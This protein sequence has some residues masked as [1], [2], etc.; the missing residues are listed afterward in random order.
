MK[1]CMNPPYGDMISFQVKQCCRFMKRG[2]W[3]KIIGGKTDFYKY[4]QYVKGA[5]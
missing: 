2:I 3:E 5:I 1:K 4:L